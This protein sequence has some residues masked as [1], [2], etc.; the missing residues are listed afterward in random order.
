MKSH[1][2]TGGGGVN[3][4]VLETGKAD[5]K[6]ILFVHGISQCSLIWNRQ[7]NSDL[8]DSFRLIA[9]DIRGHGLSDKPTNAYG[10]SKLWAEDIHAVIQGLELDKPI[11]A[12]WSYGGAI[13]TDYIARYGEDQIS[14]T[15]WV[16][17]VCRLGEPLVEPGFVSDDFVAAIPGFF[18]DNVNESVAALQ[19]LISLCIPK[20]LT[21]EE[22]YF[23]LGFNMVVPPIVRE[24]LLSRNLDNDTVLKNMRKPI[25]LSW[26]ENDGVVPPSMRDH[27]FELAGHAR[28]SSYPGVGHTPFWEAPERFNW[29]LR[30]FRE[31]I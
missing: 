7:M 22:R 3:L 5:G 2:I 11:V 6:A 26:G 17:A 8:A 16:D 19:R 1:K 29:E 13:I 12:C 30:E 20:G 9:M 15:N 28:L 31:A 23:L 27:I 21:P 25:L 4:H 14:G 10:D 24:G 18:S